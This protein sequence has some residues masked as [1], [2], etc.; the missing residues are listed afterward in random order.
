MKVS[1][2][3]WN[4]TFKFCQKPLVEFSSNSYYTLI[5]P[6]NPYQKIDD[7]FLQISYELVKVAVSCM[8]LDNSI[9]NKSQLLKI[10]TVLK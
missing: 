9:S 5:N 1:V 10:L 8:Y 6:L 7:E 2:Y 3:L 4:H